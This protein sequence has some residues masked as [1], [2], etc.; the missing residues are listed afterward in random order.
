[1]KPLMLG[2]GMAAGAAL[3][4]TAITTVYPDVPRRMIRDGKR[5]VNMGKRMW[6]MAF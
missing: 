4:V 3:A 6:N 2:L 1:M 5:V